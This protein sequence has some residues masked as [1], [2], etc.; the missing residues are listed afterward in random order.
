MCLFIPLLILGIVNL[1][2]AYKFES[3]KVV[4]TFFFFFDKSLWV[5]RY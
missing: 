5:L 4:G 1:L 3:F 2:T